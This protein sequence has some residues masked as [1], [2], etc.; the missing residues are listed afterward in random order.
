[1]VGPGHG[2]HNAPCQEKGHCVQEEQR[3]WGE[4]RRGCKDLMDI[5]KQGEATT[6]DALTYVKY[7]INCGGVTVSKLS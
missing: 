4:D 6:Y 3:R 7:I 2:V 5:L 1:M